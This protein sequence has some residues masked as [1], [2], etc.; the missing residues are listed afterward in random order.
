MIQTSLV[1]SWNQ[2]Q[3]LICLLYLPRNIHICWCSRLFPNIQNFYQLEKK[4]SSLTHKEDSYVES[5]KR[6]ASVWDTNFSCWVRKKAFTVSWRWR[7]EAHSTSQEV[8]SVPL[9]P[10]KNTKINRYFYLKNVFLGR[11]KNISDGVV[12][13]YTCGVYR[14]RLGLWQNVVPTFIFMKMFIFPWWLAVHNC[15]RNYI[16]NEFGSCAWR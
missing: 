13:V 9:C 11:I 1:K 16:R 3:Q 14:K 7:R 8:Y 15:R 2:K 6:K 4:K 12:M 10:F 5:F